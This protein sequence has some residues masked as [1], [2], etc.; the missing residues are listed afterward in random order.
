LEYDVSLR[1]L[2]VLACAA[3][4]GAQDIRVLS[5]FRRVDPA[6]Q[7]VAAD[8]GG[9]PREILSPTIPRNAFSSFRIVIT[10]PA[11]SDVWLEVGQ[12]PEDAVGVT[13]YEENSS[14]TLRS[15]ASPYKTKLPAGVETLSVW[16]DLWVKRDAQVDRIKV[17][18]QLYHGGR[19]FTYP[20]EARVIDPVVAPVKLAPAGA[21]PDAPADAAARSL[22]RERFCG[23]KPA[24]TGA[25]PPTI[26]HL[27]RRNAAQD[28]ALVTPEVAKATLVKVTGTTT[29]EQWC[30]APPRPPNGPE[31]Y[32]RF[33]DALYRA[34]SKE[35][36]P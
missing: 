25:V 11:G 35:P 4:A 14:G 18:P 6:G 17:E 20:M 10:V 1:H 19:W 12:N 31:W 33:R 22:L 23:D 29:I 13:L 16:M 3:V 21:P 27:T 24:A 8:R 5:E 32:L 7:I 34:A 26:W 9:T 15:V 28:L 36:A 2:I 30:K